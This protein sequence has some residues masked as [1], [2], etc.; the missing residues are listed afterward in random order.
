[1]TSERGAV[2]T[3]SLHASSPARA[4]LEADPQGWD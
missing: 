2:L 1:M 4:E 3:A